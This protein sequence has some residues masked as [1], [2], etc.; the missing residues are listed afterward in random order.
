MVLYSLSMS[1]IYG[2]ITFNE[3]NRLY[4]EEWSDERKRKH[5]IAM[6]KAVAKH[7]ESYYSGNHS[8]GS[9]PITV[10]DSFGNEVK[11]NGKYEKQF[12]DH[13]T[14][15]GLKWTNNVNGYEYTWNGGKHLYFPDFYL[16]EYDAH[17]EVK[18]YP[19][20]R[21]Y[22]KMTAF[23]KIDGHIIMVKHHHFDK[24]KSGDYS[25]MDELPEKLDDVDLSVYEPDSNED[26]D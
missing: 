1:D 9:K 21:D 3:W 7:P 11:I 20:G 12:Y 6:K 26:D 2:M 5:S 19:K 17:I 8:E 15:L 10:E 4:E 25:I 24:M 23:D 14:E 22:Y 16:P 18:G 13:V